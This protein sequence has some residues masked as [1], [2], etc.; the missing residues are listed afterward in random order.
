MSAAVTMGEQLDNE[1]VATAVDWPVLKATEAEL[2]G[3]AKVNLK[4]DSCSYEIEARECEWIM[5]ITILVICSNW[6]GFVF[7]YFLVYLSIC[8]LTI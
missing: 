5:C 8:E 2:K 4:T 7:D 1:A 3:K 6:I